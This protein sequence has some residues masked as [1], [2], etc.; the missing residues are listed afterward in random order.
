MTTA[1]PG[2]LGLPERTGRE[3]D[4]LAARLGPAR[5]AALVEA[6]RHT[7]EIAAVTRGLLRIQEALL[8][9]PGAEVLATRLVL[10]SESIQRLLQRRPGLLRWVHRSASTGSPLDAAALAASLA[11]LLR[12]ARD[13]APEDLL[14]R[15]RRFKARQALRLAARDLWLGTPMEA[16]GREQTALAEALLQAALPLL[17]VPLRRGTGHRRPRASWCWGSES[18]A[19]RTSTGARTSTWCW[20]TGETA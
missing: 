10:A 14:R 8:A 3:L 2:T 11:A 15:V 7:G 18:S 17:E 9:A 4:A 19:A 12:R 13:D 1:G 5:A 6:I 16:L 20:C